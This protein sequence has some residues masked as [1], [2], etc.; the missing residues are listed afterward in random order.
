[1]AADVDDAL[2]TLQRQ[3]LQHYVGA[4]ARRIEQQLVEAG[5]HPGRRRAGPA[6]RSAAWNSAFARPLCAAFSRARAT[7]P[8]SPSTPTTSPRHARQRQGEIAEAAEQ[9]EHAVFRLRI[10]QLERARDHLLVEAGVDLDEVQ[11][12]EREFD[13]PLRQRKAS[14]GAS[15]HSGMHRYR[16]RRAAGRSRNR[17]ACANAISACAIALVERLQMAEHQRDAAESSRIA[18][19]EFDLR[20]VAA[21]VQAVHQRRQRCDAHRRSAG[22]PCGIRQ[23]RDEAR[24]GLAEADQRLVL[25]LDAAHRETALAAITPGASVSGGSTRLAARRGRCARGSPAARAAWR[26]SAWLR[27]RCCSAQPP[28]VPKCGQRGATRSGDACSTSTVAAFVEDARLRRGLLRHHPSR[29]AA[30]RR[31]TRSC[32][33]DGARRRGRRG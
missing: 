33:L 28:Q 27:S 6:A 12:P 29:R 14:F 31:R 21:R 24:I 15:G 16:R 19:D 30:R 4:G 2:D 7:R 11:R 17:A 22:S 20:D 8:A 5:A 9:V 3:L 25:L 26:G 10:E 23:V 1:M 13:V 32:R 18:G